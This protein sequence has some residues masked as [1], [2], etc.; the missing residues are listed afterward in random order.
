MISHG[1]S[2]HAKAHHFLLYS[3]LPVLFLLETLFFANLHVMFISLLQTGGFMT[4]RTLL[5]LLTKLH[6]VRSRK[7]VILTFNAVKTQISQS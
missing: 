1:N 6:G 7:A 5:Y 3:A 2:G 4:M